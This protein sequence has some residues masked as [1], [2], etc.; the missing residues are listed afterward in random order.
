[1]SP[2]V[3]FKVLIAGDGG[4]GKTTLLHRYVSGKFILDTKMT[5]GV[6]ILKKFVQIGD[7]NVML[8]L[9]DF[10][11]QEQFRFMLKNYVLGAHGAIIMYDL[12]RFVSLQNVAEWVDI[13]R[14]GNPRLPLILIGGKKDLSD[15][16]FIKPDDVLSFKDQYNFF[17]NLQV[18]SKTGEGV[19]DVFDLLTKEMLGKIILLKFFTNFL[20]KKSKKKKKGK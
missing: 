18:S 13:V 6:E 19:Q 16:I 15:S 9:W 2:S 10:G 1:M 12:T 8:Q 5:L 14:K 7:Y 4:V 17:N 3:V 11:G 20:L